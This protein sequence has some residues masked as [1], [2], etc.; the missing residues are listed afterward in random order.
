MSHGSRNDVEL[1]VDCV[2]AGAS[3]ATGDGLWLPS[4]A[5][6]MS[7]ILLLPPELDRGRSGA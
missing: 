4:L 6:V 2:D 3:P 5:G 1:R 7:L